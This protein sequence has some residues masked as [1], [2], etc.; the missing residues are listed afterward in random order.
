MEHQATS[1]R[2]ILNA[3]VRTVVRGIDARKVLTDAQDREVDRWRTYPDVDLQARFARVETKRL[4]MASHQFQVQLT[5]NK[6]QLQQVVETMAA[7]LLD[8]PGAGP[9]TA[10]Q[11]IV[12]YSHDGRVRSEA[13]FAALAG[14]NPIPA[15]SGNNARHRLN[16]HG[17]QQLNRAMHTIARKRMMLDPETKASSNV[18][19]LRG[20]G[21]GDPPLSQTIHRPPD[22]QKVSNPPRLTSTIEGSSSHLTG[23]RSSMKN[24]DPPDTRPNSYQDG[25]NMSSSKKPQQNDHG[26]KTLMIL[27][28]SGDL[29]ARLLLPGLASLI[30]HG[31]ADGLKLVGAGNDDWSQEK[32]R[33]HVRKSFSASS[34]EDN[35]ANDT[36]GNEAMEEVAKNS[37]YHHIDFLPRQ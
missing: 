19:P 16:R 17:D 9:V 2:L 25:G 26:I 22:V 34:E 6:E 21:L 36:D 31:G 29:T 18:G 23:G 12:S 15:S 14:E 3:L 27:G 5:E 13:A 32:W 20:E 1:N 4:A 28:A 37:V 7:G 8:I 10:A 24:T 30:S 33:N 11:V 35:A